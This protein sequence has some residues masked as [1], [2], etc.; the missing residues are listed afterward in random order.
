MTV[1]E[2]ASELFLNKQYEEA[3]AIYLS[4]SDRHSVFNA[5]MMEI[6]GRGTPQDLRK[7]EKRLQS[8]SESGL[9]EAR[10]P[11]QALEEYFRYAEIYGEYKKQYLETNDAASAA[12]M[13]RAKDHC[14]GAV[15]R[16]RKCPMFSEE[17]KQT[18]HSAVPGIVSEEE[19]QAIYNL[20]SDS[21]TAGEEYDLPKL[22]AVMQSAGYTK[23][24]Y[25]VRSLTKI[26]PQLPFI[27][28][29]QNRAVFM[30]EGKAADE[31]QKEAKTAAAVSQPAEIIPELSNEDIQHIHDLLAAVY[32]SG[33]EDDLPRMLAVMQNAG[34][35]KEHYGISSLTKILPQL[36][37]IRAEHNRAVFINAEETAPAA[38]R[39]T[40]NEAAEA[41]DTEKAGERIKVYH[42]ARLGKETEDRM[43]LNATDGGVYTLVKTNV[44]S[45]VLASLQK[46]EYSW[47]RGNEGSYFVRPARVDPEYLEAEIKSFLASRHAGDRI[48]V[49][50]KKKMDGWSLVELGPSL[51]GKLQREDV[52]SDYES[53]Q[54]GEI[55]TFEILRC[56][57]DSRGRFRA[58]LKLAGKYDSTGTL[59]RID[60]LPE[61][62]ELR[63]MLSIPGKRVEGL[64]ED[65]DKKEPVEKAMGEPITARSLKDYLI[66]LYAEQKEAHKVYTTKR[67]GRTEIELE[68]NVRDKRGVPLKACLNMTEGHDTY[69]LALIGAASPDLVMARQV[70]VPDWTKAVNELSELSLPENWDYKDDPSH[71]KRILSNYLKYSYYKAWLD[72]DVYE[73]NGYGI[74]NTGLVDRAYDPIYCLLVPNRDANDV[75][76]RKWTLGYFACRGKGDNGKDLNRR[77]SRY[78][79]PPSYFRPEEAAQLFFDTTKELY[80]DYEHI[81]LD[82]M[83][84]LPEEFILYTLS[85]DGTLRKMYEENRPFR[86]IRDHI[87]ADAR[88]MRDLEDGLKR[89]VDTA[90]KYASWNY[91]T[92]VPI[93]YPRTNSIS[94]LLPLHLVSDRAA[95]EAALVI[96]KLPNG[97]YQGQTI[98][99]MA[100]AYQDA[101]QIARPNSDWLQLEE[102]REDAESDE[103]ENA[104]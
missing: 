47:F 49:P 44:H 36:P 79:N 37:F 63:K 59:R 69:V 55:Y 65:P 6:F 64:K 100:M 97:N 71:S 25:G 84:R 66:R 22:L 91:K 27:R 43:F 42:Y 46:G 73:E 26:L 35:T 87:V 58:D 24:Y 103:E 10:E 67:P 41:G 82:N 96:E 81:L 32:T 92:A 8:L 4:G 16:L 80:C 76:G 57:R 40:G 33:Q 95:A 77:I 52:E 98:F 104:D 50:L 60:A 102:V 62:E 18:A 51:Q 3:Y 86:M 93:Y 17:E 5:A 74:F 45:S 54:E 31:E 20:L 1:F 38:D 7:A 2:K 11:L 88:L 9:A 90:V 30:P 56:G 85:Y 53:L 23:E 99:T 72:G 70:F 21:C 15:A 14:A 75:F 68:L 12:G 83:Y 13:K 78:P 89:A 28:A 61:P 29:E 19:R 101:R 48:S 39:E 34:Y 94:L